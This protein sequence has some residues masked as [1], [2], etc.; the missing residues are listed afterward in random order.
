MYYIGVDLGGTNIVVALLN[1]EGSIL[2]VITKDTKRERVVDLIF[3]DIIA[4]TEEII[5]R[6]NLAKTEIKGIGIGSPGMIDSK[7]GV[8]VYANNIAIDNFAAVEYVEA[9]TGITTKIANDADC[10]ALGE[11]IAGAAKGTEDAVVITLGTGVGGGIIINGKIFNGYFAG[12]AEIGHQIIVKDGIRCTCGNFGCLESYAS[13]TALINM[14]NARAKEFP[15]SK[16]ATIDEQNMTAKIPFDFAWAGDAV[17]KQLIEDYID[18]VAIG[19]ANIITVFKPQVVL[20]GGGVSK[21]GDKL[22]N[23]LTEKVK[24]YAFGGD[25]PTQIRVAT[26]GNDAGI[27]G[28]AMLNR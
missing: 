8:I 23:P 17:A 2:D 19:V 28:A 5:T 6:N 12:G 20:I 7:A 21:Q 14:A 16:L 15:E 3:D 4:S 11:V 10:A 1:E 18:Y 25:M 22:I 13:A 27:V 24:K 9:R 26:L